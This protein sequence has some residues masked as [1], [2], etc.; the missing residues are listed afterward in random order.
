MPAFVSHKFKLIFPHIPRTGGTSLFDAIRPH[1]GPDDVVDS[2]DKHQSLRV[3][4]VAFRRKDVFGRY[5]KFAVVRDP[6]VRL[7]SLH[8]GFRPP[9]DFAVVVAKLAA[10]RF[11]R[12]YDFLWPAKR[13]LC[14]GEGRNLCDRVFRL[15]DGFAPILSFLRSRGVPV[16]GIPHVNGSN[17]EPDYY[18]RLKAGCAPTTLQRIHELYAWD[19]NLW[20]SLNPTCRGRG[21]ETNKNGSLPTAT[22]MEGN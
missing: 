9:E 4:K 6:F 13:W 5:A 14:D 1:L 17:P 2:L 18:Q 3:L 12:D 21:M 10:G 16:E 7:A 8:R 20:R 19:F 11:G 15:E 22:G